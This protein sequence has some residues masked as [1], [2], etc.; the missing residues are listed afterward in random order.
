MNPTGTKVICFSV[1][2]M[3]FFAFVV[4]KVL[5]FFDIFSQSYGLVGKPN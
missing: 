2:F 4:R 5:K 1:S 3:L